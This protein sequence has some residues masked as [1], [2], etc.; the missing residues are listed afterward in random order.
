M[1]SETSDLE[2]SLSDLFS[3]YEQ[4]RTTL[5][6]KWRANYETFRRCC[7]DTKKQFKKGEGEGWRSDAKLG[8]THQKIIQAAAII[9]DTMMAG[10]RI[11]Y[12]LEL[13][14]WMREE[15][16]SRG[17]PE[18]A[19]DDAI[20]KMQGRIDSYFMW[21]NADRQMM[22]HALSGAIYGDTYARNLIDLRRESFWRPVEGTEIQGRPDLLRWEKEFREEEFPRWTWWSN[23]DVFTDLEDLDMQNNAGTFFRWFTNK[24]DLSKQLRVDDP[25]LIKEN[26]RNYLQSKVDEATDSNT[27]EDDNGSN[28]LSPKYDSLEITRKNVRILDFVGKMPVAEVKQY[29]LERATEEMRDLFDEVYADI[30]EANAEDEDY[31][32]EIEIVASFVGQ[33]KVMVKFAPGNPY[34]GRNV[35]RAPWE[36]SIDDIDAVGVSDN[37]YDTQ[38]LLDGIY[39]AIIDN[40]KLSGNVILGIKEELLVE[41]VK[42]IKPGLTIRVS[43]ECPDVRQA[44]Q[45]VVIPDVTM[46]LINAFNLTAGLLEDD[47]AIPRIQQGQEPNRAETAFSASTRLDRSGKYFG[48]VVRN[49]D[50]GLVEPIVSWDYDYIMASSEYFEGKGAYRVQ[51]LGFT[52][53]QNR[54]IKLN[55]LM[56]FLQ[57]ALSHEGIYEALNLSNIFRELAKMLD[58]DPD[59]IAYAP[60]E[61]EARKEQERAAQ[62]AAMEMEAAQKQAAIAR[63]ESLARINNVSAQA[64]AQE[65]RLKQMEAVETLLN[66]QPT[67][68]A[69]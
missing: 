22:K 4:N 62:Q 7:E 17:I 56:Q 18:N 3:T 64:K 19:L 39:R 41:P 34:S 51:A 49:F 28:T 6:T 32:P 35:F 37:C 11:N 30:F 33:D 44:L 60:E 48:Q 36:D 31:N 67:E 2:K 1:L 12:L 38:F 45:P 29:L 23:W 54:V 8:T 42:E 10:G 20:E 69:P 52:S 13:D 9:I 58:L 16:E 68:S 21:S 57:I 66:P 47:S 14:P 65:S 15:M 46:G 26:L 40:Q 25:S 43:P 24:Y 27:V 61:L 59:Q 55:G 50:E 63:D 5:E 53:Y